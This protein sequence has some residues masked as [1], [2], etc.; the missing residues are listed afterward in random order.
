MVVVDAIARLLPGVLGNNLSAQEDSFSVDLLDCPL[1]LVRPY[2]RFDIR[3]VGLSNLFHGA[4]GRQQL[5][6][7]WL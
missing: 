1:K 4:S 5:N 7:S 3:S 2:K 6:S